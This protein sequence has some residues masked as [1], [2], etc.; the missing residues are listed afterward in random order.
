MELFLSSSDF[1]TWA[2]LS[3]GPRDIKRASGVGSLPRNFLKRSAE[4]IDPPDFNQIFLNFLEIFWTTLY[5]LQDHSLQVWRGKNKLATF[6]SEL[7]TWHTRVLSG[8]VVW[9]HVSWQ[10]W[11][12]YT[13][14][15]I[16]HH[17]TVVDEEDIFYLPTLLVNIYHCCKYVLLHYLNVFSCFPKLQN[18][19]SLRGKYYLS[20]KNIVY[21]I[22]KIIKTKKNIW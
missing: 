7:D 4:F 6:L 9:W 13:T 20:R 16:Q 14:D 21:C 5:C 11:Q 15:N 1:L 18:L 10:P 17:N 12:W 19:S 3:A 8:H 2:G 22:F